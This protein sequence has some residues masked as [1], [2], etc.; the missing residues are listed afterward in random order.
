MKSSF[1]FTNF[2]IHKMK[3]SNLVSNIAGAL[4]FATLLLF[5]PLTRSAQA[6]CSADLDNNHQIDGVDLAQL[7]SQWGANG[8]ADLNNNGVVDGPDL[9]QLLAQ[10]GSCSNGNLSSTTLSITQTWAQ[11]PSG[12][13]R[14]AAV[15]VPTSGSGPFPVVIMLHGNGGNSSFINSMGT[16]L[17]N[18]IRVAPNGYSTSWNVDNETSKA[19]DVA[20]IRELIALL[21]T[22][23][24]VDDAKISI[25]GVSNGSGM[26]NR[27]LI[28]L[29]GA[30]FQK[31]ACRV[32]Q[33]ITKMYHDGSFW[34]NASGDNT[35]N[36]II[37][38]ANG[39]R[40]I[41]ISG[42][43]DTTIPYT[44]GSGVGTTFMNCQESIY[45]FAQRMGESGP[46]LSD[47]AGIPGNS[48]NGYSAP[49]VKYTYLNGQVVHYK[50]IGGTH[51][52]SVNGSTAYATEA[53][54]IIATFLLQ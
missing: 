48:T 15:L 19:P 31:A 27:L 13:T 51:G 35:Y 33:M 11:Q 32:S 3:I 2:S 34:F 24:N 37:I 18:A 49:F 39:R 8:T 52:L 50:L 53:N 1:L 54:Q 16:T 4:I 25:Y 21:K 41:S 26:T 40:I 14:T 7:L 46:Q 44:G 23:D 28:E 43:A 42:T 29:D 10:W 38:P 36:Q 6:Q 9:T 17:N 22:Y 5:S 47:A 20:F 30:A 45:R 12:Y